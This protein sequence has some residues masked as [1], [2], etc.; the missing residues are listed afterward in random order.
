MFIRFKY[1]VR[2]TSLNFEFFPL[3]NGMKTDI[4][5]WVDVNSLMLWRLVS[6]AVLT[7][8]AASNLPPSFGLLDLVPAKLM[9]RNLSKMFTTLLQKNS[10]V[11]PKPKKRESKND[12]QGQK[13][14]LF[15]FYCI[16]LYIHCCLRTFL[17]RF[18]KFKFQFYCGKW[19][20]SSQILYFNPNSDAVHSLQNFKKNVPL[21]TNFLDLDIF[22]MLYD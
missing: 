16:F 15:I 5:L 19:K 6:S 12:F 18:N 17:I 13:F 4:R 20:K 14:T 7:V 2:L 9:P 21:L 22:E 3:K 10:K 11:N 1:L 8:N